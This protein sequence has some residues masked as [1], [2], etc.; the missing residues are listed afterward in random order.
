MSHKVKVHK[1]RAPSEQI[2]V[3]GIAD[4]TTKPATIYV[5]MVPDRSAATLIP[6]INRVCRPGTIIHSDIWRSY[7]E[8]SRSLR[9]DYGAV[10]H[11]R[12]FVDPISGVHTQAIES[13]WNRIKYR[14]KQLKGVRREHLKE[15]LDEFM[16]KS[17]NKQDILL[18]T[19]SILQEYL[20]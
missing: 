17:Q 20:N 19:I 10:D 4:R 3:F 13:A 5:E 1:G 16:W 6:I 9:Y 12:H 2:W 8:L 14:F 7:H 15:Y 18:N 11:S